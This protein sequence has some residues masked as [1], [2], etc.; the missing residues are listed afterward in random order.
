VG[1]I[2]AGLQNPLCWTA[3]L[4]EFPTQQKKFVKTR[5]VVPHFTVAHAVAWRT[6]PGGQYARLGVRGIVTGFCK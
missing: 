5:R 6:P 4:R 3:S 1:D 2:I